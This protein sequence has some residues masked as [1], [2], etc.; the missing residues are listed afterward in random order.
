[1]TKFCILLIFFLPLFVA[2]QQLSSTKNIDSITY[3]IDNDSTLIKK[4]HDT[5]TYE[6]EDGG[7]N[8]DSAYHHREFFYKNG[9]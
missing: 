1:M 7:K 6:K 8:W 4:L 9:S 5:E 2:G 3:L